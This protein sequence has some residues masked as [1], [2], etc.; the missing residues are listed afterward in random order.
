MLDK[1]NA[2]LKKLKEDGTIQKIITNYIGT[3]EE[4]GTMP[5]EKKD[6]ERKGKLI[7]ATNAEFPPYEYVDDGKITGIDMDIMQAICDELG[8]DMSIENMKF[9]S[10]IARQCRKSRY[11]CRRYDRDRGQIKEYRLLRKLYHLQAGDYRL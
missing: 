4:K 10:I 2:A 7:V 11:R 8:M 6:V 5:Y 3:D 1:V 9:D